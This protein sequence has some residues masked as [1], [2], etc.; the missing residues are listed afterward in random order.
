MC[1]FAGQFVY[2]RREGQV[3]RAAV[4]RMAETLDHRG[5]DEARTW[6]DP[7]L[8][9][10]I[11]FRRL[12]VIDPAGGHQPVS[13]SDGRLTLAYNGEIYN[14][15]SLRQQLSQEGVTFQSNGDAEVLLHWLASHGPEGIAQLDGMFSAV[16]Y[17]AHTNS[18]LLARDRLGQKPLWYADLGDSLLFASEAKG[19]LAWPGLDTTLNPEAITLFAAMGYVPG[20]ASA[21]N[22]LHKFPPACWSRMGEQ[23]S[24]PQPYW[25]IQ[26]Q[27]EA[28]IDPAGL[29]SVL[30]EALAQ[31]LVADVPLGLLLSGGIDSAITAVL[32]REALGPE[33]TIR[34]FTARFEDRAYDEGPAARAVADRLGLA[35][36]ELSIQAPGPDEILATIDR[37]DEPFADSS[38]IPTW[39]LC[40]A[41]RQQVTVALTGDGGDEAFAG[42]DR[43]RAMHMA[44]QMGPGAY[45]AA[46]MAGGIL[47]L[48]APRSERSRLRRFARFARG[49]DRP[50]A[51]QYLHYRALFTG[52]DLLR[53]FVDDWWEGIETSLPSDWFT[54]RYAQPHDVADEAQA[55][56]LH[57]IGTYLPDD[58]LVKADISSMASGLELRSAF[59]DHRVVQL[60]VSLP[61]RAKLSRRRGKAILRELFAAELPH[62]VLDEP[63]R[64]FGVPLAGWFRGRLSGFLQDLLLDPAFLNAGIVRPESVAGLLND[65]L[66]GRA[67]HHHRLWMLCVLSRWLTKR[68]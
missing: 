44:A 47:G 59:L 37:F 22:T 3:D 32:M 21:W 57:D 64:G 26:P 25:R 24:P 53:L 67:D 34:S 6:V 66:A 50:P 28:S 65:H 36:S 33:A 39:Q 35:H 62:E 15:R 19:L 56:Q 41:A 68:S 2:R 12:A 11:G 42:Y 7:H 61:A 60:G 17:D 31:R 46:R 43:H 45:L 30:A 55:A 13:T 54:E 48:L 29:R 16:L 5:P 49:L 52:Q 14:Y 58:L 8:R 18:L 40:R 27:P 10:A 63:K 1:G 38:A 51:L 4:E 20:P 9:C 23:I